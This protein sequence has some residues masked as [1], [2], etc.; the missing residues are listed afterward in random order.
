[1]KVVHHPL[2]LW[3]SL[4][5]GPQTGLPIAMYSNYLLPV[6]SDG[7]FLHLRLSPFSAYHRPSHVTDFLMT[8]WPRAV[9]LPPASLLF[10][11]PYLL[12]RTMVYTRA[13]T[14]LSTNPL[15]RELLD[16]RKSSTVSTGASSKGAP[17][18]SG[19][20]S[21]SP[22]LTC[23]RTRP[24]FNWVCNKCSDPAY[25]RPHAFGTDEPSASVATFKKWVLANR[26]KKD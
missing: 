24:C 23:T 20:S 7:S 9:S 19:K 12:A 8:F 5:C 16:Q 15:V 1:M 4:R 11:T 21:T 13:F 3:N 22:S 25:T 10:L 14:I 17:T 2:F 26:M 18:S 6:S